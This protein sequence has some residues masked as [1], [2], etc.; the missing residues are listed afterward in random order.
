MKTIISFLC[1]FVSVSIGIQA[2]VNISSRCAFHGQPDNP[3]YGASKAGLNATSQS[4][5]QKLAKYR[6]CVGVVIPGFVETD[7]AAQILSGSNGKK[8]RN[9]SPLGRVA[10]PDEVAQAVLFLAT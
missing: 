9:Q 10:R 7:T 3:A 4:L 1:I 5:A 6:I 8:I 2:D